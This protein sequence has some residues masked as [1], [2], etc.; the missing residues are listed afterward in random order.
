[1]EAINRFDDIEHMPLRV[2]NRLVLMHN[3][4]SDSGKQA[5]QD[6]L[7]NFSEDEVK[8]IFILNTYLSKKGQKATYEFVTKGL[9]F[10]YNV[11]EE[12]ENVTVH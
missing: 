11:G 7:E 10:Q 9:D 8:Q 4:M 3:L 6:Y 1:M 12:E 2:Y 5:V